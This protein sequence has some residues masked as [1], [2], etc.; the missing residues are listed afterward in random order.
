MTTAQIFA[1]VDNWECSVNSVVLLSENSDIM[2][3]A[4]KIMLTRTTY[5]MYS[6]VWLHEC[7]S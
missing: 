7:F 5:R 2:K 3:D 6:A 4:L 1:P